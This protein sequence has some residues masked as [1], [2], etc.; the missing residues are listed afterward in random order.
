MND[1]RLSVVDHV[2]FHLMLYSSI[3]QIG[4]TCYC[5]PRS[6]AFSLQRESPIFREQEAEAFYHTWK[7]LPSIPENPRPVTKKTRSYQPIHVGSLDV[8]T[9]TGSSIVHI[10][11]THEILSEAHLKHIRN[12]LHP[13]SD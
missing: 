12:F 8:T 3:L 6:R 10:G 11:S 9:L 7:P 5:N 2:R 13:P 4:D 1:L